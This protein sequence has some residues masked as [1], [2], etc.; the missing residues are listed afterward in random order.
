M[1]RATQTLHILHILLIEDD[2]FVASS[3]QRLLRKAG[4]ECDHAAAGAEGLALA[5][6]GTYDVIVLDVN[7]PDIR[8]FEVA[9]KL[10]AGSDFTPIQMLTGRSDE[11]DIIHGLGAGADGYLTKPFSGDMLVAH[12]RALHRRGE[13]GGRPVL[14]FVD[15]EMDLTSREVHRGGRPI[16]LTN[17]EFKLLAAL[18]KR[19]GRVASSEALRRE[20]W[21]LDFDPGTGLV[22]VH[23][24]HVRRKLEVGGAPRCIESVPRQGYRMVKLSYPPPAQVRAHH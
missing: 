20:V 16:R 21:G 12:L 19:A 15:V 7:L 24:S 4:A 11:E 2:A 17:L 9:E 8:G 22:K 6:K 14:Q 3:I 23:V 13:M 1:D 10:R 5:R 18:V